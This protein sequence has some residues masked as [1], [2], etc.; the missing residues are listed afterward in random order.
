MRIFIGPWIN[1]TRVDQDR[2]G[3]ENEKESRGKRV[4]CLLFFF[5]LSFELLRNEHPYTF[6]GCK[7]TKGIF[8]KKKN[9]FISLIL[10]KGKVL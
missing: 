6:F 7:R 4:V 9:G 10:N 1:Q 8:F 3:I 2:Y 5:S